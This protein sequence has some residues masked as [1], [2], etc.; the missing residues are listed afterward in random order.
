MR[1]DLPLLPFPTHPGLALLHSSEGTRSSGD[2]QQAM[3]RGSHLLSSIDP[4]LSAPVG[5]RCLPSC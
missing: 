1:T 5:N 4:Y 2:R 3:L